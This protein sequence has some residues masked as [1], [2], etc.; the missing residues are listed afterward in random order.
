MTAPNDWKSLAEE[1]AMDDE[2]PVAGCTGKPR[3]RGRHNKRGLLPPTRGEVDKLVKKKRGGPVKAAS[4][5][6]QG[7]EVPIKDDIG[8]PG[9]PEPEFGPEDDEPIELLP[10][11]L[12]NPGPAPFPDGRFLEAFRRRVEAFYGVG[13]DTRGRGK[14]IAYCDAPQVLIQY[15]DGRKEWWREDLTRDVTCPSC[16]GTG[17]KP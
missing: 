3:H 10:S 7:T 17:M 11:A 14:V 9:E 1:A 13:N 4:I 12:P 8:A 16:N 6:H 15:E 2:C 5:E